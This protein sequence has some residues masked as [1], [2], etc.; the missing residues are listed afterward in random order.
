MLLTCRCFHEKHSLRERDHILLSLTD[1]HAAR[2]RT[3]YSVYLRLR[4]VL[5]SNL[6]YL[7]F[8][9]GILHRWNLLV[10]KPRSFPWLCHGHRMITINLDCHV[11]SALETEH[12]NNMI[13]CCDMFSDRLS[14]HTEAVS[15]TTV[16]QPLWMFVRVNC[17]ATS[18]LN[19]NDRHFCHGAFTQLSQ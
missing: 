19:V 11:Y 7:E 6:E 16:H 12:D 1:S 5:E 14:T 17:S 13:A 3:V 4:N 18:L 9:L 2:R 10:I 15:F 8:I